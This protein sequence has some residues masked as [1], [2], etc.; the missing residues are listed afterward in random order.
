MNEMP[1]PDIG[2]KLRALRKRRGLSLRALAEL[3]GL[4]VNTISLVERGKTSPSVATLHRLATALGVSMTFFFEEEE[5]RDVVFVKADHR[6]RTRSGSVIMENLGSGL[7]DQTM[8]P[9]LVILQPRA[10]SG[11][12]PIVHLGHEFVFCL[13]GAIEY[14]IRGDSYLLDAGDS[15]IFGAHLP[16]RWWNAG[17]SVSTILLILQTREGREESVEQHLQTGISKRKSA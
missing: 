7:R 17:D 2:P 16:H 14:E 15:L 1:P 4:S 11:D 3:C 9:L 12:E 8:E 10:D 13:E 6:T 5:Q